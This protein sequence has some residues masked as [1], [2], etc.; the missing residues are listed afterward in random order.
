[1]RDTDGQILRWLHL[2]IDVDDRKNVEMALATSEQKLQL[3]VDTIP[4]MV[5][6]ARVD[7]TAVFFN[8]HYLDYLGFSHEQARDWGWSE[9]VHPSDL[10]GLMTLWQG[11]MASGDPGEAQ[12]RLRRH[13]GVYRWFLFRANSL[14]DESGNIV[15]WYGTNTD[16]DELS[17]S[18]EDLRRSEALF[19]QAQKLART[20]SSWWKPSTGEFHMSVEGFRIL[21]YRKLAEPHLG[22]ITER[23]HPDDRAFVQAALSRLESEG[24]H[25]DIEHRL[26]TPPGEVKHVHVVIQNIGSDPGQPEFVGAVS[27]ITERKR[28]AEALERSEA[29]LAEGQ[30]LA[31]M[32]NFSWQPATGELMWSEPLYRIFDLSPHLP[33]SIELVAARVHPDDLS[34][35]DEVGGRVQRGDRDFEYRFRICMPDRSIKH[36]HLIAHH[37]TGRTG[38]S[39]YV[40]AVLDITQQRLAEEALNKARAQ[41]VHV[42]RVSSLGALTASIAHEVNQPLAGIVTN[43]SASLRMLAADPP[44]IE[45]AMETARRTIRD[46]NRAAEVIARLRAL[47]SKRA[48]ASE[49]VDVNEAAREVL[50]LLRGELEQARVVLHTRLVEGLPLVNGD[51]IQL[52]EVILNLVRNAVDAMSTIGDRQR[53]LTI[54]TEEQEDSRVCLSVRDVGIGFRTEDASRIFEAFY[55]TKDEG[56]GIGLSVSQSII[57]GHQ[58][59]LWATPNG[60]SG[61]TFAFSIPAR[62]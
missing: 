29:F 35:F 40:G 22:M 20:G 51:R 12:A 3:I 26:V 6:S 8:Q 62:T 9:A 49:A 2:L 58:G 24:G 57:E 27:D 13:D 39:R 38:E 7:G 46:G 52:Q 31:R 14:R 47:F 33:A 56:M 42:A 16:V 15:A 4:A 53:L 50:A 19:A 25:L 60:E 59:R 54:Q 43:A 36:L 11:I 37:V 1:L 44:N 17:R 34:L 21:G 45:R 5:W 32:G 10:P 61:A 41:L 23:C 30:H 55:T 18:R 48:I 28:A